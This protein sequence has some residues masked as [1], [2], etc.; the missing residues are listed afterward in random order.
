[1][2]EKSSSS[3]TGSSRK[4]RRPSVANGVVAG[5]SPVDSLDL[6]DP[7]DETQRNFRYQHAYGAILLIQAR[8][9]RTSYSAVWCEQHEDLLGERSDGRYD[10]WQI[11]TR[12]PENGPWRLLDDSMVKSIGR[13]CELVTLYQD[14]IADLYFASN[15]QVDSVTPESNDNRR[16]S[17]CPQLF[18]DHINSCTDVHGISEPFKDAFEALQAE[19]GTDADHLFVVLK[20]MHIVHGPSRNDYDAVVAFDHVA[21]LPECSGF[22]PTNIA[23]VRDV[24][25]MR[26]GEACSLKVTTGARHVH[27]VAGDA[28]NDP[29]L[30]AKRI[31]VEDIVTDVLLPSSSDTFQILRPAAL[32]LGQPKTTPAGVVLSKKLHRGGLDEGQIEEFEALARS[33]EYHLMQEATRRPAEFMLMQASLENT[34]LFECRQAYL[35]AKQT[36]APYGELLMIDIQDRL[37]RTAAETPR[38]VGGQAA[39]CLIGVAGLLTDECR[40]WFSERFPLEES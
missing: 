33:A 28:I 27:P 12:T 21:S 9:G 20:R 25:I 30:R 8:L 29:A 15:A 24:L 40:V 18:L 17:R 38:K 11:K 26:V 36:P 1:M 19:T 22:T 32:A 39:E 34:V 35:R 13:F 7:G 3:A 5:G 31:S 4:R 2:S 6:N 23:A 14:Q 16:R 37:T 10:G